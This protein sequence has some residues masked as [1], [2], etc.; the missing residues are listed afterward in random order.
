[1]S[2]LGARSEYV[3]SGSDCGHLFFWDTHTGQ[4]LQM[5]HADK[6][7]AINCLATHPYLPILAS[8]GL[9]SDAKIWQGSGAHAPLL[10]GTEKRK[11]LTQLA[12]R[13]GERAAADSY[14]NGLMEF[15]LSMLNRGD[16]PL[17][18]GSD[19]EDEDDEDEDDEEEDDEEEEEEEDD[20]IESG[21]NGNG[22]DDSDDDDNFYDDNDSSDSDDDSS[23]DSASDE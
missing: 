9:E 17:H 20:D 4:T 10:E 15:L 12:E 6:A 18:E 8:S 14:D 23:D 19:D 2:F 16:L 13:N 11:K 22:D 3:V 21:N 5:L 7:G 1:V